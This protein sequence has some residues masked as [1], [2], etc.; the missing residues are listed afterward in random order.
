M[1]RM[2][3]AS[4]LAAMFAVFSAAADTQDVY[5]IPNLEVDETI[6]GM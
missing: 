5:T 1:I 3:L 6:T 2:L 4:T